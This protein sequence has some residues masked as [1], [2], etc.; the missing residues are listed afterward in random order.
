MTELSALEKRFWSSVLLCAHG[1]RC[2]RCCHEWQGSR[3]NGYGQMT[4]DGCTIRAHRLALE[5]AHGAGFLLSSC[6][7]VP[8][9]FRPLVLHTCDNPPCVNWHHLFVGTSLDNSRDCVTRGGRRRGIEK[10]RYWRH[11]FGIRCKD[12]PHETS[13]GLL[14]FSQP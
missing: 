12:C 8:G 10:N 1:Q 11:K 14:P 9:A 4:V 2:R 5:L 6:G 7:H 13:V 3:T